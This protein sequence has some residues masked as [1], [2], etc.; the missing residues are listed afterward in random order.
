[1]KII[2]FI[3]LFLNNDNQIVSFNSLISEYKISTKNIII[4]KNI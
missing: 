4:E 2:W 1:M 3:C